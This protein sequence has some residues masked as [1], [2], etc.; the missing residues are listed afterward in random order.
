MNESS[1]GKRTALLRESLVF[2]LKLL[3][4][5][6]R[7]FMLVPISLVATG[8]GLLRSGE[9]PETEFNRVLDLGRKSEQWINLF[10][11]HDPIAEAGDAGSI[12]RLLTRA[13]QVVREQVNQGGV[14]DSASTAIERALESVHTKVREIS[15]SQ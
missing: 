12:D 14:S 3:A 7:D 13:E 1:T 2:Q 11:Q 10:G 9:D 8:V 5:G 6:F 4:D 15:K